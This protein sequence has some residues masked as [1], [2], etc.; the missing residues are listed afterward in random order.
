MIEME[1]IRFTRDEVEDLI[2]DKF[3]EMWT[4][5]IKAM[6]TF[7]I[8]LGV[9]SPYIFAEEPKKEVKTK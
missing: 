5:D 7:L 4:D 1:S 3:D 9:I 2:K 8:K 6:I